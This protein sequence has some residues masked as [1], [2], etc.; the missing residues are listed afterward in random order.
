MS[1]ALLGACGALSEIDT[2][3][4][5]GGYMQTTIDGSVVVTGNASMVFRDEAI[6]DSE[7]YNLSFSLNDGGSIRVSLRANSR[8]STG[9]DLEVIRYGDRYTVEFEGEDLHM[10]L[11]TASDDT[12]VRLGLQL[13]NDEPRFRVWNELYGKDSLESFDSKGSG[14]NFSGG[15]GTRW[16]I[17][18]ISGTLN[19]A[20]KVL[21]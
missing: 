8:L 6:A 2:Y 9:V 16:G 4:S 19:R 10:S 1:F 12:V 20:Q 14:L 17:S 11:G 5:I 7:T 13:E 15:A 18:L 21:N 3:D